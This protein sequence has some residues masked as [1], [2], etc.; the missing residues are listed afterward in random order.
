[1]CDPLFTE[2]ELA[3]K[4]TSALFDMASPLLVIYSWNL[5][6]ASNWWKSWKMGRRQRRILGC[7]VTSNL[8]IF[9]VHITCIFCSRVKIRKG[10]YQTIPAR[11]RE[12]SAQKAYRITLFIRVYLFLCLSPATST[13]CQRYRLPA[14]CGD[15]LDRAPKCKINRTAT[16]ESLTNLYFKAFTDIRM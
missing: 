2:L 15:F 4:I 6:F 3:T 13:S 5:T 11:T 8:E 12:I 9:A 16:R 7:R 1:M 10:M 14:H